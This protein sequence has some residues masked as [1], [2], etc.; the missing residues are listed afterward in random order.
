MDG[1][2]L[3][4]EN[5]ETRQILNTLCG[6]SEGWKSH[7]AVRSWAKNIRSLVSYGLAINA[8]C[9][10]RGFK[11]N[12][13]AY[14]KY[15]D[16]CA[17]NNLNNDNPDWIRNEAITKSHRSRLLCKGEI[18]VLCAAIKKHFKF[19]KIDVW[20]KQMFGLTKNQLK[21]IH[22]DTLKEICRQHNLTVQENHYKQFNWPDNPANEYVWPKID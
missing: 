18:D 22:I 21:Y 11:D 5:L 15:L 6:F 10:R 14:Q 17:A 8:E 2:R 1:R 12:S 16:Y 3:V 20:C 7:P 9:I 4:K 13:A 19:K